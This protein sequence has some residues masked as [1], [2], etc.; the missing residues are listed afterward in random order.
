MPLTSPTRRRLTQGK[1]VQEPD[2]TSYYNAAEVQE[3]ADRV[4][5]LYE[6]WPASEW[7]ERRAEHIAVVSPYF[8]QVNRIRQALRRRR[9][10]LRAVVVE[11]IM[12]MQGAWPACSDLVILTL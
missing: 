5:E 9:K 8:D 10:E 7:G 11:R 1:E 4:E 2:S 12:N 3:V 6:S